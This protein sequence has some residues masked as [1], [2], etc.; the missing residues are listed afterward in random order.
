MILMLGSGMLAHAGDY[1]DSAHGNDEYGVNRSDDMLSVYATGNCAH[2]HE[3]HSSING[4][5]PRPVGNAPSGF[6]LLADG[7]NTSKT[8]STYTQSDNVCFQCHA[9]TASLQVNGITNYNYSK[10]FGG[11]PITVT[12]IMDAFKQGSYHNL[13]DIQRYITGVSGTKSFDDFPADTNPCSGCHNV[14]LARANWRT[15]GDPISTAISLPSDHNNLWGDDTTE[16]MDAW[17]TSAYQPPLYGSS[18]TMLEPDGASSD[19]ATQAVKTPDYSTF[20]IDCH[21]A[22]DDV[23]STD[24]GR[25]LKKFNWGEEMHGGGSAVDWGNATEMKSPYVDTSLG[26]YVLS[27]MDCHE[28]HGS[29]NRTLIRRSVNTNTV[30]LPPGSSDWDQLCSSCHIAVSDGN[31]MKRFHHKVRDDA[32]YA[33][34]HC[35][36][37][38]TKSGE[39]VSCIKC[40]YHSS[41]DSFFRMF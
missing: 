29:T 27:C 13:Y 3:Q 32:G 33:C 9:S 39:M 18:S 35:H 38:G 23:Y 34:E 14:H 22:N 25:N 16:R 7:F 17:G 20:C 10:N 28:P 2:C 31:T 19:R 30:N 40:H 6:L 15:P 36:I 26:S 41:A 8:G 24:K 21:N 11:A 12:S 1:Q 5:E 4:E 37:N